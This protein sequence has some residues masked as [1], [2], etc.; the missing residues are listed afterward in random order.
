MLCVEDYLDA[1]RLAGK[2]SLVAELTLVPKGTGISGCGVLIVNPPWKID[3]EAR[4]IVNY[5]AATL[6][7]GQQAQG[8]VRWVVPK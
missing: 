6:C 7:L 2:P 5:L 8:S 1:L 4:S 3:E